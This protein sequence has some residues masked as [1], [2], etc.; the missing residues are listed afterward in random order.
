MRHI[1]HTIIPLLIPAV[2]LLTGCSRPAQEPVYNPSERILFSIPQMSVQ[3]KG[4]PVNMLEEE[5][6]FGV[7]G[8]CIPD[9]IHDGTYLYEYGTEP[10]SNKRKIC[11]PTV[12]YGQKVTVTD[13]GCI[14]NM[15]A[16]SGTDG[17]SNP[18]HWYT[19]GRGLDGEKDENIPK[20]ADDFQYSFFAYYPAESFEIISP[21]EN[22][23]G[24]PILTFTMPFDDMHT[25]TDINK[26]LPLNETPDAMLSVL[27]NQ[28]SSSGPLQFTMYH[29]L[30][31]LRFVINNFSK[32][33]L[34]VHS[35][36]L[37]GD[38][39]RKVTVDF[40]S[41]SPSYSFTDSKDLETYRYTGSYII[42]SEDS[43]YNGKPLILEAADNSYSSSD[44]ILDKQYI[45]LISGENSY[46][47]D[48]VKVTIDYTLGNQERTSKDI[49]RPGTFVPAPGNLYFAC[50]NFVGDTFNLQF[51]AGHYADDGTWDEGT[52]DEDGND[53]EN[54]AIFH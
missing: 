24:E 15:D 51:V 41:S 43:E 11:R 21:A 7:I 38:F 19:A 8:Y 34:K 27:Y 23:R 46:F 6:S 49:R 40:T 52:W 45:L 39:F 3:T 12:F 30:T 14:Y 2:M 54:G 32:Y 50:L 4:G 5:S 47:G 25:Q 9:D 33:D 36:K 29:V 42:Y 13:K 37:S 1:F 16:P 20:N 17:T 10:W 53:Y 44:D 18:K 22:K 28:R 35:L 31:G 48:D 26:S